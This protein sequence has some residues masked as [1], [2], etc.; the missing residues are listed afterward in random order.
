[1]TWKSWP[2]NGSPCPG[3]VVCHECGEVL[4]CRADDPWRDAS[5]EAAPGHKRTRAG[6]PSSTLLE[7]LQHVLLLSEACPSGPAGDAIRRAACEL[8]EADSSTRSTACRRR[9]L[10]GVVRLLARSR[11][12]NGT[13]DPGPQSL[14][15][16]A[17]A[18]RRE[19]WHGH[20]DQHTRAPSDT[21][22]ATSTST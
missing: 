4:W 16:L 20:D 10:K 9:M 8:V 7:R 21:R 5:D 1:M 19:R 22:D 11:R 13:D 18:L 6:G 14:R 3:D 15:Q 17:T 2:T 12:R